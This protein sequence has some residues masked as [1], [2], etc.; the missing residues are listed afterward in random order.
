MILAG[1][2][3]GTNTRLAL[4]ESS[5][6]KLIRQE[7]YPSKSFSGLEE[8]LRLFLKDP[9]KK[10]LSASFG[11]AGPIK[12]GRCHT[13]NLPWDIDSLKLQQEFRFEKIHLIN[14]LEANAY[15]IRRLKP[16]EL[17]TLNEGKKEEGNAVLVSAGTGLGEAGLFWDGKKH[18][19]FASEGG[20][21]D[22]A[23]RNE[24]EIELWRYLQGLFGH[25]SYERV[26]S[27]PGLYNLYKFLIG[28]GKEKETQETKERL[29]HEPAAVV[30]TDMALK[31]KC[32]VCMRTLTWFVEIYGREAGNFALE[33]LAIG[34]VY[35][36][37]GI[38]PKIFEY[39]KKET[40][41]KAF[42]EKGRFSDFL[43]LIPIYV[44]LNENTALLGAAV[45]AHLKVSND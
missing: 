38:A 7:K 45:H 12:Q 9:H 39:L 16:N 28:S 27:G 10:I 32:P 29:N 40:F 43:K 4:F 8:I 36:G 6:M 2:I 31:E 30:I 23:P 44:V 13:T 21:T 5:D 42:C 17:F 26:L 37:G 11:V 3:G 33:I 14:D 19:P 41:M 15:G 35:L 34:G 24:L 1:D 22:F 25:V 20:H 18:I